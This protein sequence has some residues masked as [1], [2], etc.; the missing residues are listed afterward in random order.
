MRAEPIAVRVLPW[1]TEQNQR[2]SIL[3][4]H[5]RVLRDCHILLRRARVV[6]RPPNTCGPL[7]TPCAAKAR[8]SEDVHRRLSGS[9]ASLRWREGRCGGSAVCS[10]RC[11][12]RTWR[13]RRSAASSKISN[14]LRRL[15]TPD[16]ESPCTAL[17]LNSAL[18]E[19]SSV[20]AAPPGATLP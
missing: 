8:A 5:L 4:N 11:F 1:R 13:E 15:D 10:A 14:A 18:R 17:R 9:F 6:A 19:S 16:L 20:P 3:G 2:K 12:R 7:A